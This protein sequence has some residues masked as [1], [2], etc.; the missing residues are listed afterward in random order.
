MKEKWYTIDKKNIFKILNTRVEGL[1]TKEVNIRLKQY[2]KNVLPKAKQKTFI[3]VFFEQFKNPIVYILLITMILSFIIGEYIDGAF[4]LFVILIDA[5]LGSV[6]EYRSNKNAE[7]LAKLIRID[8]LVI[9]NNKEISIPSEDLVPGDIVLLESGS[10]VP[11]DL[12]LIETQ[13]L[14]IDES[15]LTGESIPR[16]KSAHLL[17]EECSL[18]E[19]TNMAYLGTSVMRGRAKGIVVSTSSFTEIGNIAK[20]VLETDD[21][22]T[23]LQIR[24]QKFTKQLGML[25]AILALIVTT[26]LYFKGYAAKEI[27]FLVVALSIS[28]IPEGLPVVITLSLSISSNKMAKRN[29]LVKKLNAVEALGSA[30]IIASDKTGTLT[31]NEQ[32]VKKIV[33][34]NNETYEVTG[35]G[36]N[37][38]GE[39]KPFKNSKLENIDK[40]V[41]E[42]LYNNE[43]SLA[44]IDNSWVNFGDSMD[45]ALLSLGYKYN[46]ESESFKNDVL[47][48]IPYESDAGYS[49]AFYK[50]GENINVSVKGTL[51]KILSFCTS[52]TDKEKI[53]KQNEDLAKE[54]Y[55]V[56]AFATGTIKKFKIK[57]NYKENDIP[58]LTFLGLV[59]FVDPIRPDAKEAIKSCKQ[60]GIKTVMITGDH[61]LT[62]FSVAKELELCTNE[63]EITTGLE[64]KEVY[65]SG[66]DNFV[67]GDGVNDSPALKAANV[68]IA[69][70]SGTDVAKETG[71]LIITDD[72]F[73]SILNGVEEGRCAYDNVRKVTYM[74]LSCG[75][76]E[77]VFYILSIALNYDIPLTAVQLLWLNLV[78]DGIQDVALSF[79][80]SEKDILKRKPR[81]PKESL[82]DRLLKNEI[83]LIGLIMGIT[84]FGV[85][86]YLIDVLGY[87]VSVARSHILLL[88]VFLQNLHCFNC[89]SEIHSIFSKPIK[90]NKQLIISIAVV[91]FI[92]FIV[93]ENSFLSH[94][95]DS[96]PIP[97]VSVLYLFL[98]SLPII[99]VSEILKYFER[100]KIRRNKN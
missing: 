3:Q 26:I 90:E 31:L 100:D 82:F 79:E 86:I 51:E 10:K 78:T 73:S 80:G 99:I 45:T 71:A 85:W 9:R 70:G 12:R 87:E 39:I 30:T 38:K 66:L 5:V 1:T 91:L 60:A 35:V 41:K 19:R 6:Q 14:T 94:L 76:S 24:M 44:Y 4:I 25:T 84:V 47:G 96:N 36:Y 32:T 27:F 42:G 92:Q 23:P 65:E 81:D 20:E 74:L 7:A 11:A 72:K 69:M 55:R 2:G 75:V 17:S 61:P 77:V 21:T 57:D 48:R 46:L 52:K 15:L 83:M 16:E 88:M 98:L 53:R 64:L 62:A 13:N 89:R 37:D 50:E 28:S 18:S 33:L 40:L 63:T 67:T 93:V 54:G 68:G 58:K 43:A 97:L 49:C 59:A 34:P 22:I 95:L 56:L 8:A 29:V